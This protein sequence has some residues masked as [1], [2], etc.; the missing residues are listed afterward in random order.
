MFELMFFF[1]AE[2][3]VGSIV[4]GVFA[5][6]VTIALATVFVLFIVIWYRR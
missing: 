3:V 4:G 2:G 5:F 1:I 6:L